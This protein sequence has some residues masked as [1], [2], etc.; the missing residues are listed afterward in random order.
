LGEKAIFNINVFST[1]G[2]AHHG[3]LLFVE[4]EEHVRLDI[5][6][7]RARES[8]DAQLLLVA[9]HRGWVKLPR[10]VVKSYFPY[11]LIR[12]WAY[13]D[14]DHKTLIFPKPIASKNPPV[15][16]GD[17]DGAIEV[18]KIRG[19]EFNGFQTYVAGSP[20]SQVAW[21]QYARG[22]GLHL[23]DYRSNQG[24]QIWLLWDA[25]TVADTELRLSYLSYWVNHFFENNIEFGLQLPHQRIE[26]GVG[27]LHRVQALTALALYGWEVDVL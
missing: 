8:V 5:K 17:G 20:L 2:A 26:L 16:A 24:Q 3:V 14:I 11:G 23:K 27:E 12:A 19:D 21:K 25:L 6:E 22:A 9:P 7:S 18:S 13:V 4:N 10:I 15:G 1:Y